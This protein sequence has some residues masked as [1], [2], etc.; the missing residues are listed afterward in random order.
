MNTDQITNFLR[1]INLAAPTAG[2][3]VDN[4][5]QLTDADYE[6]MIEQQLLDRGNVPLTDLEMGI[7]QGLLAPQISAIDPMT[8][9]A[10]T[11][12]NEY[13]SGYRGLNPMDSVPSTESLNRMLEL[14][15]ERGL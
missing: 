7:I 14:R 1:S 8:S 9:P 12:S 2:Q 10:R 15:R 5:A 3:M 11:L 4:T 6:R 13:D